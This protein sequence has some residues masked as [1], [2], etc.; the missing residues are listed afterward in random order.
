MK[1]EKNYCAEYSVRS[2]EW[3]YWMKKCARCWQYYPEYDTQNICSKMT[4]IDEKSPT[5]MLDFNARQVETIELL[6][7]LK[8]I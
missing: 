7:L 5:Y 6:K 8:I 3:K 4:D 2:S 1:L